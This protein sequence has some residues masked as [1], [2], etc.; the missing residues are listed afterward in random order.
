MNLIITK[1]TDENLLKSMKI[2]Y[3]QPKGF[4]GRNICYAIYHNEIYYG[5]IVAGSSTRFLPGRNEFL[6]CTIKDLNNIINNIYYHIEKVDNKY[7]YRNFVTDV[8]REFRNISSMDWM[9]K[10]GDKVIGFESLVELPRTGECYLKDDWKLVGQTI[11]YTC[12]RIAGNGTDEWTGKRV[13]NTKDL[14]PK[15]VFCKKI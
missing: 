11:G 7:P 14:R 12:K 6:N 4:V 5:H 9:K 1:R 2:H 3:S 8:I 15:L 10:Y 13:W